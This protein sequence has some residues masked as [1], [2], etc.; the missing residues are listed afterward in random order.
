MALF[1]LVYR[2]VFLWFWL[3]SQFQP[4]YQTIYTSHTHWIKTHDVISSSITPHRLK[5]FKS[6]DLN[7]HPCLTYICITYITV[8]EIIIIF[9]C[10]VATV[11]QLITAVP[12]YSCNNIT[13]KMVT[14]AAKKCWRECSEQNTP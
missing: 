3:D 13:L 7:H 4:V 12:L 1:F 5:D 6:Q 9:N 10:Y 14:I 8:T 11:T 2:F